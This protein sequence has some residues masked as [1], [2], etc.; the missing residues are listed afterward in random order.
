MWSKAKPP[1]ALPDQN[2]LSDHIYMRP[3]KL[4]D[5]P[6]WVVVR[7]ENR[8]HLQPF[9][10]K[11]GENCFEEEFF[12]RRLKRQAR[13]WHLGQAQAFLI[14]DRDTD[15]LIGGMNIY[16]I[17]R[18]AAQFCSL[19]YWIAKDREGRGLMREALKLTI[20]YCFKELKLHRINCSC[21]LHNTRSKSLLL[22]AGFQEEGMAEHYLQINGQWQDHLL[23]GLPVELW[24]G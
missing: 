17:C 9:E 22:A 23:F 16:N 15:A 1:L 7:E 13:E 14:F 11:W 2:L 21:L 5:W 12:A 8:E 4:Q 20:A 3:A 10:P 24:K 6:E 19:G 18:G